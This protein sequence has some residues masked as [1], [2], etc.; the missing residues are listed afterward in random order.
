MLTAILLWHR[1][2]VG[3]TSTKLPLFMCRS[4]FAYAVFVLWWYSGDWNYTKWRIVTIAPEYKNK[5]Q[6]NNELDSHISCHEV[7][8]SI[9]PPL[10]RCALN[11][12]VLYTAI[13]QKKLHLWLNLVHKNAHYSFY[14]EDSSR[15][16]IK[17]CLQWK[18]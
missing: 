7:N 2:I 18:I 12:W 5:Y 10:N 4:L 13:E 6:S 14:I 16:R 8:S 11:I 17:Q 15:H 1:A 9:T 3:N